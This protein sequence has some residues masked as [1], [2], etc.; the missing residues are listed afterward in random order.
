MTQS[1]SADAKRELVETQVL[2]TKR[3]I[4][5]LV[6]RM[7]DH[8]IPGV[9]LALINDYQLEW[10]AGY[11]VRENGRSEQIDSETLF[12][13]CSISKA[14]TAVAV[15][16]LVEQG[17][18]ELDEDVN[19]FLNSWKVTAQ[20]KGQTPVTIRQLLSHTAGMSVA[21]FPGYH[22]EQDIPTLLEILDGAQPSSTPEIRVIETPGTH[23]HY[24]GGGYAVLQQLLIDTMKEP[25]PELMRELILEPLE[26]RRSTYEQFHHAHISKTARGHRASGKPVAGGWYLYPELAA[27]GLWTTPSDLARFA[28]ELQLA[29][30][31]R[32]QRLLSTSMIRELLTPQAKGDS[33]GD[34]GLG[35]FVQGTGSGARFGHPGDNAGFTSCWVSL[36]EDGRGCVLMTNSDKGWPLQEELLRTIEQV[37]AWPELPSK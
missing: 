15:L 3:D 8:T 7:A 26:M 21:W 32:S 17:R 12:Q 36:Q 1:S 9:S 14:V 18:L 6:Q 16:R 37:Y 30:G 4:R 2:S 19:A 33:R 35:I 13:A 10:A 22:R 31:G 20:G 11:G 23:F 29:R 25:F 34:M 27:A 24:S 28:L 5:S